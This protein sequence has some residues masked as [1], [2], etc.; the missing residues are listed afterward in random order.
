MKYIKKF[1]WLMV[2]II[3][4]LILTIISNTTSLSHFVLGLIGVPVLLITALLFAWRKVV[5]YGKG[6]NPYIKY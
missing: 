4:L 1:I 6:K 5:K 2:I 3:E